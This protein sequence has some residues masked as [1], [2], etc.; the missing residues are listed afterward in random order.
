MRVNVSDE[1]YLSNE[2]NYRYLYGNQVLYNQRRSSSASLLLFGY[3]RSSVSDHELTFQFQ[4]QC[5]SLRVT[6]CNQLLRE[7]S[8]EAILRDDVC[9]AQCGF[10]L[11]ASEASSRLQF[12]TP[13]SFAGFSHQRNNLGSLPTP[14]TFNGFKFPDLSQFIG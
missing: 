6:D 12:T 13:N 8:R 1:N 3:N 2:D 4:T 11:A 5:A 10:V 14:A 9:T 7:A